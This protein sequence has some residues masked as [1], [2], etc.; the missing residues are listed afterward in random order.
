MFNCNEGLMQGESLS[1]FL[2]SLYVNDFEMEFI[3]NM[4]VPVEIKDIVLF[5][6]MYAD[7]T[8]IITPAPT[9]LQ[10]LLDICSSFAKTCFMQFNEKKTKLMCF[11]AYYGNK[12]LFMWIVLHITVPL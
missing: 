4:C 7:D 6:I 2:F 1:P 11:R 10:N 12:F 3:E 8:Y 5:L 9:A